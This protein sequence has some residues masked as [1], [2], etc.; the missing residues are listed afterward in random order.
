MRLNAQ[1]RSVPRPAANS[2]LQIAT[3]S[4]RTVYGIASR[5]RFFCFR[6]AAERAFRNGAKLAT[7][8][9]VWIPRRATSSYNIP[10]NRL[11]Q[12]CEMTNVGREVRLGYPTYRVNGSR[13]RVSFRPK[14]TTLFERVSRKRNVCRAEF[15]RDSILRTPSREIIRRETFRPRKQCTVCLLRLNV[16][17][18]STLRPTRVNPPVSCL[19][20]P[21]ELSMFKRRPRRLSLHV[22]IYTFETLRTGVRPRVE[23]RR[24]PKQW[25]KSTVAKRAVAPTL[26]LG[27]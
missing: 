25:R 5:K 24:S 1:N 22:S 4:R 11:K 18:F 7:G 20:R 21:D 8:A 19:S 3:E 26:N 13:T 14:Q 6:N 23:N 12:R 17:L 16:Y 2:A 27:C 9:A 15:P 10:R